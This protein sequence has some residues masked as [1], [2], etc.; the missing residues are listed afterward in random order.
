MTE[1]HVVVQ[2]DWQQAKPGYHLTDAD[3]ALAGG[4]YTRVTVRGPD[5]MIVGTIRT[6]VDPEAVDFI[7][8][9]RAAELQPNWPG[10]RAS[11]DGVRTCILGAGHPTTVPHNDG[12]Q[13][14]SDNQGWTVEQPAEWQPP[15]PVSEQDILDCHVMVRR[16]GIL[17]CVSGCDGPAP[18][19]GPFLDLNDKDT[20]ITRL[21]K[22]IAYANQDHGAW[23]HHIDAADRIL[24]AL[25][26]PAF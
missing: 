25:L 10:C 16:E 14:W 8:G 5:G 15:P 23:Q 12:I 26:E 17:Y 9:Q 13:R 2:G 11:K 22:A 3:R 7:P 19:G 21:A 4:L 6:P 1:H 24:T 20:A 18:H